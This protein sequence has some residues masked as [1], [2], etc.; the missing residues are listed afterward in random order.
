MGNARDLKEAFF[1]S[2]VRLHDWDQALFLIRTGTMGMGD[3][4]P[5]LPE[6]EF[7]G[8]S[9]TIHS[10]LHWARELRTPL[11]WHTRFIANQFFY[12]PHGCDP[13]DD[14][15]TYA[16]LAEALLESLADEL[17][18]QGEEPPEEAR[19]QGALARAKVRAVNGL[20]ESVPELRRVIE[21]AAAHEC[22]A[23]SGRAA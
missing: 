8:R 23:A 5:A 15:A 22:D 18:R 19:R 2:A 20:M 14:T 6:V 13:L 7:G 10:I 11:D 1:A 4:Y 12:L 16:D 21:R 17:E 9:Y 3:H